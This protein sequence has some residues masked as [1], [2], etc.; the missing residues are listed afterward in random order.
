MI[1]YVLDRDG[2]IRNIFGEW[3][4]F[5]IAN[6]GDCLADRVIGTSLWAS[7]E[8]FETQSYLNAL[9]FAVLLQDQVVTLDYRCD[10]PTEARSFRMD[11]APRAGGLVS[12]RHQ[13]QPVAVPQQAACLY[14]NRGF[15]SACCSMCLSVLLGT[16]WT[17]LFGQ[18][19]GQDFP[20]TW[21]VCP[22]CRGNASAEV[23]AIRGSRAERAQHRAQP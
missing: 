9:F 19:P 4:A 7:V 3:D 23:Q 14:P 11:I 10:S 21:R 5:A 20:V 17:P 15:P 22:Q 16:A 18:V 8:G 6:G 13:P 12:V 2:T 1:E